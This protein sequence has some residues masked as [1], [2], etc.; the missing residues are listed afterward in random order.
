KAEEVRP[1]PDAQGCGHGFQLRAAL[2]VADD[3]EPRIRPGA[4]D[5]ARR[6]EE[7]LVRLDGHQPRDD[8]DQRLLS[9]TEL[10]AQLAPELLGPQE[11]LQFQTQRNARHLRRPPDAIAE[12]LPLLRLAQ[13]DDPVRPAR[14]ALLDPEEE[15]GLATGEIA[16]EDVPVVS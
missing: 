9:E 6:M 5:V 8:A 10:A 15:L 4:V 7:P 3:E 14:Q 13:H 2:A 11:R 16:V 12:D 1:L